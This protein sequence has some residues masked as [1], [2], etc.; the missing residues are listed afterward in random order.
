MWLKK[1][2]RLEK[3]RC[4]RLFLSC[5]LFFCIIIKNLNSTTLIHVVF[6]VFLVVTLK[7]G[8]L[9]SVNENRIFQED[10]TLRKKFGVIVY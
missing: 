1:I 10:Q 9:C 5:E 8:M 4:K 2:T 6:N 7:D 3:Y